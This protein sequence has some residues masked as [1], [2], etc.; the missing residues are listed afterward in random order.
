MK[1]AETLLP[2]ENQ[3]RMPKSSSSRAGAYQLFQPEPADVHGSKSVAHPSPRG[4]HSPPQITKDLDPRSPSTSPRCC[5]WSQDT[6]RCP[7]S[8]QPASCCPS[9]QDSGAQSSKPETFPH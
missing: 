6:R 3:T 5:S 4:T 9:I 8:G 1:S 2:P 7:G